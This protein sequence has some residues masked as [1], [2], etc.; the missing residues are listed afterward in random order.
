MATNAWV[1]TVCET[2]LLADEAWQAEAEAAALG[3]DTELAEF[4]ELHPRPTLKEAML[5]LAGRSVEIDD[6]FDS[7]S[8]A[9]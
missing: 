1:A 5:A 4:A 8:E 7:E 9:A 3:Y 6:D 2:W